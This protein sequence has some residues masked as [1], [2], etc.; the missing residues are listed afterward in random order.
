MKSMSVV[1]EGLIGILIIENKLFQ[2]LL[3]IT[4]L[5]RDPSK[6]LRHMKCL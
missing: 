3:K 6:G 2:R 5:R 4:I 1:L